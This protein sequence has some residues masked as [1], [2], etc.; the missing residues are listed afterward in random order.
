MVEAMDAVGVDGALLVS[1]YS[2][3]GFDPT[4][5]LEVYAK[6]PTRYRLIKPFDPHAESVVDEFAEWARTPGVVGGRIM[7][8][9]GAYESDDPRIDRLFD[10]RRSG[11]RA[12]QRDGSGQAAPLPLLRRAPSGHPVGHR[13]RRHDYLQ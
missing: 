13:P 9:R 7:L 12:P 6:H 5:A 8:N 2:L 10:G 3:Y 4:Y 11:R 1:P